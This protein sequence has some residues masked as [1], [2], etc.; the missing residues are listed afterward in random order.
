VGHECHPPRTKGHFFC[1]IQG[2]HAAMVPDFSF[3]NV[4]HE[5]VR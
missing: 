5:R 1:G 2:A 3:M 4:I